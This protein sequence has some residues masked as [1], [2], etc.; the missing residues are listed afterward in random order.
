MNELP[1][2]RHEHHDFKHLLRM[3]GRHRRG[4]GFRSLAGGFGAGFGGE[5]FRTGR[6]LASGDLQLVLL[7][8][9]AEQ[10]SHGYEL[11]KALEAR[12]DGYYTPSPG[13]IYPALTYLEE[14]GYAT[15]ETLGT[16]KLYRVT[17]E[18]RRHLEENRTAV[19]AMLSQLQDIGQRMAQ[20]RR[21][22]AGADPTG[23]E[24]DDDG[25]TVKELRQ[26]RRE[27]KRVL[28]EKKRCSLEEA[29]RVA[30]ILRRA[31]AEILGD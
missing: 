19:D 18:G 28:H 24:A 2:R 12:S 16:K 3:V 17:E 7:A 8:L 6:K 11:I 15:V 25:F 20:V 21:A 14:L 9:L 22:F 10:P 29:G 23:E 30:E 5:G 13:M 1:H 26:A 31:A 4:R 27:L